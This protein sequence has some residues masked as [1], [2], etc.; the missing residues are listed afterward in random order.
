MSLSVGFREMGKYFP[1]ESIGRIN[2]LINMYLPKAVRNPGL[3]PGI[4][5]ELE[6]SK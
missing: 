6:K 5:K 3:D 2:E 1:Y 4:G